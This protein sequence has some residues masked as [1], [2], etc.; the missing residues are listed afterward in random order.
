[1]KKLLLAVI[2]LF[3]MS[4]LMADGINNNRSS[5]TATNDNLVYISS[6]GFLENIV[7]GVASAGGVLTIYNSTWT[8]TGSVVVTSVSLATVNTYN[9]GNT[10]VKGLF[11]R[12]VGNTG[13]VT[14]IY[15]NK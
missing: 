2:S 6:S 11:Y 7:V 10:Q 4:P 8:A 14:I 13:G 9:Y 1:M 3:V 12:T 5:F 15:R